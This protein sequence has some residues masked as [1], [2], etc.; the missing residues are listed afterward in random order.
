MKSK[1]TRGF[2]RTKM[3]DFNKIS[4]NQLIFISRI[5][6]ESSLMQQEF[7]AA[8]YSRAM[9]NY[10][11]TIEFL[12]K[13]K[14]IKIHK[15]T[16]VI[17]PRYKKLLREIQQLDQPVDVVNQFL[18]KHIFN[19]PGEIREYA[20]QFLSKFSLGDE[21][22]EYKPTLKQ[23]LQYSGIRN[24][25]MEL[26]LLDYDSTNEKYVI[27]DHFIVT[28][29]EL[30]E[31]HFS[32]SS[33]RKMKSLKEK[34]GRAA[35]KLILEYEKDRLSKLPQIKDKIE[36]IAIKDASA[37]Y[38]I[39]SFDSGEE[40]EFL[41]RLIEVKAVSSWNYH[42]YWTKNEIET[43]RL[44]GKYYYLYLLP[45]CTGNEFD[46]KNMKKISD[47]FTNIYKNRKLWTPTIETMSY[48][49]NNDT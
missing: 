21:Y 34:I 41:P 31:G 29:P 8:K 49:L 2:L 13:L 9:P 44:N 6:V 4:V 14:L 17:E 36:H 45:V 33:L 26:H 43:S 37:G 3:I 10:E 25:L 42:F 7:M 46:L 39:K 27:Q 23:K 47:P 18:I 48:S 1:H 16:I 22:M 32:E 5:F 28:Y 40:G 11:T 24:F 30:S 12:N 19:T 35:E 20:N 15:D 38:D